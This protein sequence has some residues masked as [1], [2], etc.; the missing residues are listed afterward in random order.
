MLDEMNY[1]I[2]KL[3]LKENDVIIVK[4]Q[5]GNMPFDKMAKFMDSVKNNLESHFPN[6]KIIVTTDEVDISTKEEEE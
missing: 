2:E 6:N 3:E 1:D 5:R 4:L